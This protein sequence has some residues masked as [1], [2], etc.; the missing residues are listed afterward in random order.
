[1]IKRIAAEQRGIKTVYKK[2]SMV[3]LRSR[4][5][6]TGQCYG[7]T[8]SIGQWL[9]EILAK[10]ITSIIHKSMQN[11]LDDRHASDLVN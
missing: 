8:L 6:N 10:S 5:L 2:F 1:M 3:R 7:M 11:N 4:Y 9:K